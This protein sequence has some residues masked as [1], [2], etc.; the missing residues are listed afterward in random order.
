MLTNLRTI[1][2]VVLAAGAL[3]VTVGDSGADLGEL[4][5]SSRGKGAPRV[6]TRSFAVTGRYEGYL[7]GKVKLGGRTILVGEK[8]VIYNA[9][10]GVGERNQH[11]D[12]KVPIYVVGTRDEEGNLTA[13]F[14]IIPSEGRGLVSLGE[15]SVKSTPST[16]N[17]NVGVCDENNPR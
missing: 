17:P 11:L 3:S 1:T 6:D 10:T 12:G 5:R 8:T 9:G 14:V 15:S 7:T 4:D 2:A 13:T 16:T